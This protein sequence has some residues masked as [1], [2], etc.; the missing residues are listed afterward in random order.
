MPCEG[1]D[2]RRYASV[3]LLPKMITAP[4][5]RLGNAA[6]NALEVARFGGLATDEEPSP[7]EVAS[8]QRV[9]RLR[10]YYPGTSTRPGPPVL[11]VPPMIASQGTKPSGSTLNT[12]PPNVTINTCPTATRGL[13]QSSTP[14]ITAAA[15]PE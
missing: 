12:D 8:E 11:L 2:Q 15:I 6:Q 3:N 7:Y 10:H 1:A 14:K 9:Y 13:A 5:G 4:A